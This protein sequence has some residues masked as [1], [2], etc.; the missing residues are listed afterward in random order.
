MYAP[1][2]NKIQGPIF[3]VQE[4]VALSYGSKDR[5]FRDLQLAYNPLNL[6]F[7][8]TTANVSADQ[9]STNDFIDLAEIKWL[10]EISYFVQIFRDHN[11]TAIVCSLDHPEYGWVV[12]S[13]ATLDLGG[14]LRLHDVDTTPVSTEK[15]LERS[16]VMA[17]ILSCKNT[18]FEEY[19]PQ[20]HSPRQQRRARE[21]KGSMLLKYKVL[22]IKPFGPKKSRPESDAMTD[23]VSHNAVHSVRGHFKTFSS[24]HPAF[25]KPWGVGTFWTGPYVCGNPEFGLIWKDYHVEIEVAQ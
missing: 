8:L 10:R 2:F 5:D 25:G 3:N 7:K 6:I 17:K 22:H 23:P 1:D 24:E 21:R 14:K 18:T 19:D 9:E 11:G 4:A 15:L 20:L 16:L 12:R 13:T